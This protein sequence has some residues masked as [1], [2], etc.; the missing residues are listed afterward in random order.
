MAS[1]KFRGSYVAI[2]ENRYYRAQKITTGLSNS[3]ERL[4]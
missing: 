4:V 2:R 1:K 3:E